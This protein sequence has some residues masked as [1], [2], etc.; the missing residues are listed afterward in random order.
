MYLDVKCQACTDDGMGCIC[1]TC[2]PITHAL[3]NVER[4]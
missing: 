1:I 2:A 4:S 3:A